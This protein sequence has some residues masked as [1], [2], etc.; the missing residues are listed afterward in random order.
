MQ[1]ATRVCISQRDVAQRGWHRRR[2]ARSRGAVHPLPAGACPIQ[3]WGVSVQMAGVG[4]VQYRELVNARSART[5]AL[6]RA[7]ARTPTTTTHTRAWHAHTETT[8]R[9]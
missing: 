2:P 6:S 3:M 5:H 8:Q 9:Q 1:L 4:R 7:H